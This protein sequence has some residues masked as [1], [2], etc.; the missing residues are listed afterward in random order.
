MDASV[1]AAVIK[2]SGHRCEYC[3][4]PDADHCWP[5]HVEHIVAQQ[6][7][8]DDSL[9][10]LAFSCPRRNRYKGPNL[11]AIDP[12]TGRITPL[13]DPRLHVWTDHF[14]IDRSIIIGKTDIGRATARLL[15][16]NAENRRDLRS[17]LNQD[18][19]I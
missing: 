6:H 18:R 17:E 8:G 1:R 15:R 14:E 5:F 2:R 11:S 9:Q 13:F 4:L 10:N 16:M 19:P 12:E 3:L 7:G